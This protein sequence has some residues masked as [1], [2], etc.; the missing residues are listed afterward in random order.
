MSEWLRQAL[1]VG[2]G[3]FLGAASRFAV[4]TAL[5]R[6]WPAVSFPWATVVVNG[7]G[8][9]LIGAVMGSVADRMGATTRLFLLVGVLG[10]F[11]TFSAFGAET[12]LLWRSAGVARA[13]ANIGL[14]VFGGLALVWLGFRLSAGSAG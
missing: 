4:G 10:G 12:L 6:R 14:Q 5:A 9:L 1:V 11:T 3:G 7:L 8:C 13:L 2:T